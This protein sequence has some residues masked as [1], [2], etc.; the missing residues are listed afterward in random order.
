MTSPS[1]SPKTPVGRA[2][3]KTS[4]LLVVASGKGGVGKTFI[5]VTLSHS[6]AFS[7]KRVLLFD[8]DLGLANIDV[9]LGLMPPYDL[10]NVIAGQVTL[11]D[12]I[13]SYQGGSAA[14]TKPGADF[15]ILAG[16]SGSGSLGALGDADLTGLIQGLTSL[17]GQYDYLIIDLP[18]GIDAA[19]TKLTLESE[20]VFVVLTD[21]PTSLTD[22]YAYIKVITRYDP[23]THFHIIV[24]QVPSKA[25]GQRTFASLANACR[26]FLNIEVRL[27]GL[28]HRDSKVKEA[29][30][31]QTPILHR[32][33]ES[34][35]ATDIAKIA[36]M[37]TLEI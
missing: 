33:P 1:Q 5:S 7:G 13:C 18:A 25:E 12:A 31:H 28:V 37:I 36:R 11:E 29:I 6:L 9:Q 27:A 10:G 17:S 34:A 26:N 22:A 14:E 20:N 3:Q 8:G 16:K 32:S 15:H 30:R 23:K 35:A 19:V 24:N 21:E 2:R 4:N